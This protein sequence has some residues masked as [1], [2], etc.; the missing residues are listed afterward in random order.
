M[1][2][3][4]LRKV[5]HSMMPT[6]QVT[7]PLF[8][9][10][11]ASQMTGD[12]N[13]D[14]IESIGMD[15]HTTL[16]LMIV[17]VKQFMQCT[18]LT[19]MHSTHA[20]ESITTFVHDRYF[21]LMTNIYKRLVY[22]FSVWEWRI[23]TSEG[24]NDNE[25]TVELVRQK[26]IVCQ[27]GQ[28]LMYIVREALPKRDHM[29]VFGRFHGRIISQSWKGKIQLLL[30]LN[31]SQLEAMRRT[32][33]YIMGV[34]MDSGNDMSIKLQE[35]LQIK[36][37]SEMVAIHGDRMMEEYVMITR[38]E[39]LME[40]MSTR[41][42][43]LMNNYVGSGMCFE[44]G[45]AALTIPR[46]SIIET[47]SSE[48]M[49]VQDEVDQ[50]QLDQMTLDWWTDNGDEKDQDGEDENAVF[51]D[52]VSEVEEEDQVI[53]MTGSVRDYPKI[54]T[55]REEMQGRATGNSWGEKIEDARRDFI[56][57]ASME[58]TRLKEIDFYTDDMTLWDWMR[59]RLQHDSRCTTMGYGNFSQKQADDYYRKFLAGYAC[60]NHRETREG[61][62]E[63][64]TLAEVYFHALVESCTLRHDPIPMEVLGQANRCHATFVE[65]QSVQT[66]DENEE[67]YNIDSFEI[68]QTVQWLLYL[69]ENY[70]TRKE[71]EYAGEIAQ[72][73]LNNLMELMELQENRREMSLRQSLA[74]ES[75]HLDDMIIQPS[76][77]L[78][79]DELRAVHARWQGV[80]V[81]GQSP[82]STIN[83][84]QDEYNNNECNMT[85]S[86]ALSTFMHD[87]P[88]ESSSE[89]IHITT[90]GSSSSSSV[91]SGSVGM[92]SMSTLTDLSIPAR[93]MVLLQGGQQQVA[94]PPV[95]DRE[96][97][98]NV[99]PR[100]PL[101]QYTGGYHIEECRPDDLVW[102]LIVKGK[103]LVLK[104]I[105]QAEMARGLIPEVSE[106]EEDSPELREM[107]GNEPTLMTKAHYAHFDRTPCKPR[108]DQIMFYVIHSSR[109]VSISGT[110]IDSFSDIRGL[111]IRDML[112]H[113]SAT[114]HMYP[115][116]IQEFHVFAVYSEFRHPIQHTANLLHTQAYYPEEFLGSPME[117]ASGEHEVMNT[118]PI[119]ELKQA[120]EPQ[121]TKLESTAGSVV[122][123]EVLVDE[124]SGELITE[125][126]ALNSSENLGNE[127][128]MV[129]TI[130]SEIVGYDGPAF[131]ISCH[132][133]TLIGDMIQSIMGNFSDSELEGTYHCVDRVDREY[134]LMILRREY[135][136]REKLP[137]GW[138][139]QSGQLEIMCNQVTMDDLFMP[140]EILSFYRF[141]HILPDRLFMSEGHRP[142]QMKNNPKTPGQE[143]H[144]N[145]L[146]RVMILPVYGGTLTSMVG[147]NYFLSCVRI[148]CHSKSTVKEV[149]EAAIQRMVENIEHKD[150]ID[151][152]GCESEDYVL[153]RHNTRTPKHE[154]D[155]SIGI[156]W[157]ILRD[158]ALMGEVFSTEQMLMLYQFGNLVGRNFSRLQELKV[159][160]FGNPSP[161]HIVLMSKE[162][163]Q[164]LEGH[165]ITGM[166]VKH[167]PPQQ[168]HAAQASTTTGGTASAATEELVGTEHQ[169]RVDSGQEDTAV[170]INEETNLVQG[171][172]GRASHWWEIRS[173]K[174]ILD[175]VEI[176]HVNHRNPITLHYYSVCGVPRPDL[177]D[178]INFVINTRMLIS[179]QRW[180]K[181]EEPPQKAVRLWDVFK[182]VTLTEL[183]QCLS[184]RLYQGTLGEE[185]RRYKFLQYGGLLDR[186]LHPHIV[187]WRL[188]N[189]CTGDLVHFRHDVTYP[190]RDRGT[191]KITHSSSDIT[192]EQLIGVDYFQTLVARR[193][194]GYNPT[195]PYEIFLDFV[196]SATDGSTDGS[197]SFNNSERNTEDDDN[198][199]ISAPGVRESDEDSITPE[200]RND[201]SS[202]ATDISTV[203]EETPCLWHN[204]GMN[205]T[206][207]LVGKPPL[208]L[209]EEQFGGVTVRVI[210][211]YNPP[212][213]EL[214]TPSMRTQL[215]GDQ[216]LLMT[217]GEL[218]EEVRQRLVNDEPDRMRSMSRNVITGQRIF[219]QPDDLVGT[220]FTIEQC[221]SLYNG[222]NANPLYPFTLYIGVTKLGGTEPL[223]CII[224]EALLS[225]ELRKG[226]EWGRI[227]YQSLHAIYPDTEEV[228]RELQLQEDQD[229]QETSED[230]MLLF[231][232]M[233]AR[234]NLVNLNTENDEVNVF[235]VSVQADEVIQES[236]DDE[237]VNEEADG[238]V[239]QRLVPEDMIWDPSLVIAS[240]VNVV[241]MD[242]Q[243][244]TES[245]MDTSTQELSNESSLFRLAITFDQL[246][247]I[248]LTNA[249]HLRR[250]TFAVQ[251][252]TKAI[253][254]MC[255]AQTE[256]V[257]CSRR[258]SSLHE[259]LRRLHE[260]SARHVLQTIQLFRIP[261]V[262]SEESIERRHREQSLFS[263]AISTHEQESHLM[264]RQMIDCESVRCEAL[265]DIVGGPETMR[266][267]TTQVQQIINRQ[268][269]IVEVPR[270]QSLFLIA[271]ATLKEQRMVLPI[272]VEQSPDRE[273]QLTSAGTSLGVTNT[274]MSDEFSSMRH[275]ECG[276][277][278]HDSRNRA[279]GV[280]TVG[281]D[282]FIKQP[283][284]SGSAT[285]TEE[286][287]VNNSISLAQHVFQRYRTR[288][289]V[290]GNGSLEQARPVDVDQRQYLAFPLTFPWTHKVQ[291]C[292]GKTEISFIHL[293]MIMCGIP[294]GL[295]T[296]LQLLYDNLREYIYAT[297]LLTSE[298]NMADNMEEL[299]IRMNAMVAE[300]YSLQAL[301]NSIGARLNSLVKDHQ[302]GKE[303]LIAAVQYMRMLFRTFCNDPQIVTTCMMESVRDA[304]GSVDRGC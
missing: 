233:M 211:F 132:R 240:A 267:L 162:E 254:S 160:P 54:L 49:V 248:P 81:K 235:G 291:G 55:P 218:Q 119:E 231:A 194:L 89:T 97:A 192:I 178:C 103:I 68:A 286:N 53:T 293:E 75:Q 167:D 125:G 156:S 273:H 14:S 153:C 143:V 90:E 201:S 122:K 174:V 209:L 12:H 4:L 168:K 106:E 25:L 171:F 112:P 155:Y 91:S 196:T 22:L 199:F 127:Q 212:H 190:L 246:A 205:E 249:Y 74:V 300:M 297:L 80:E 150:Q 175:S 72:R 101:H 208:P 42:E 245:I 272:P 26:E 277:T 66:D 47:V 157:I 8:K 270:E 141:G 159:H 241:V 96:Y 269:G 43:A 2:R 13:S 225:I 5:F 282:E 92:H 195:E 35:T 108:K 83:E 100:Y 151:K 298:V 243:E 1:S 94:F 222:E 116:Y 177:P 258:A 144:Y 73:R 133:H 104:T 215:F 37:R 263:Q 126:N 165:A 18:I 188:Q 184:Q 234:N 63:I 294:H 288:L 278:T 128:M 39:A 251:I 214:L 70:L 7:S 21:I 84:Y 6:K 52:L 181:P 244:Q 60:S 238:S 118:N 259:N 148:P 280:Q 281:Q 275:M 219:H 15:Y 250:S 295:N 61:N 136:S 79:M 290:L 257:N 57:V 76:T 166:T 17:L 266:I 161:D 186:T 204:D 252:Y 30:T 197:E 131:S 213:A 279:G 64:V 217:F 226:A 38:S 41:S 10:S 62:E 28:V 216:F 296:E 107:G 203:R 134:L 111:T 121:T 109:D 33:Q 221:T 27:I 206:F 102:T 255:Q 182:N 191:G 65:W 105:E 210:V 69:H 137:N 45:T 152:Y 170:A 180:H 146:E 120:E 58:R 284:H 302:R 289:I 236:G 20:A 124:L 198:S 154:K 220:F 173:R 260:Q 87:L 179:S 145:S 189:T 77:I 262:M 256:I 19:P 285:V 301:S 274:R 200:L 237:E 95:E 48:C 110:G 261:N 264:Q 44:I 67:R 115:Y 46:G 163:F 228:A 193:S 187:E 9:E 34:V 82:V 304:D 239:W 183:L 16:Q 36:D 172:M 113:H 78:Y 247:A 176:T 149:K 223:G 230:D 268:E 169:G 50:V 11:E 202:E 287:N 93:S 98:I 29:L 207:S 276:Q 140:E 23:S 164:L 283:T 224:Q 3:G 253:H 142:E 135:A 265:Q 59:H 85:E 147:F 158:E 185:F 229:E 24:S 303:Q 32:L 138:D 88:L 86:L 56:L 299:C 227:P 71:V 242:G 130:Q 117:V 31:D 129:L 51:E 99:Q 292:P 232:R 139:A 271:S 40:V 114:G 123:E